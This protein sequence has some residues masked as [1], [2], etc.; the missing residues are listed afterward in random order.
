[1]DSLSHG[2]LTK[3]TRNFDLS[4]FA[5]RLN[6]AYVPGGPSVTVVDASTLPG[7]T[8]VTRIN[9]EVHDEDGN[10][11][12]G[13]IAVGGGTTGPMNIAGLNTAKQ[14]R[15]TAT[16][17]L[18]NGYTATGSIANIQPAGGQLANWSLRESS[19]S[20]VI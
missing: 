2:K 18:D 17:V 11:K 9:V 12:T 16:I 19:A 4:A 5:P 3:L 13:T 14:M 7:G 1:M 20:D 10:S 15:I 8:A 6:Y